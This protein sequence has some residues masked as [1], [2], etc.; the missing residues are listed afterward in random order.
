MPKTVK[1]DSKKTSKKTSKKKI[2]C[3]IKDPLPETH[4]FGSMEECLNAGKV[5]HYGIK[6]IDSRLLEGKKRELEKKK[7]Q[8]QI[9]TLRLD[10]SEFIGKESKFKREL[11]RAKTESDKNKAQKE[12]DKI[13]KLKKKKITEINKLKEKLE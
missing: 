12:L 10:V 6:K 8:K 2:Y 7:I 4:R 1:K 9:D 13:N 3:G 11:T 5:T